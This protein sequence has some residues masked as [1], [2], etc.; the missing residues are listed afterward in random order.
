MK[1]LTR[2]G[3]GTGLR[4]VILALNTLHDSPTEALRDRSHR[5]SNKNPF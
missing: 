5:E 4:D 2:I 3:Y 1:R